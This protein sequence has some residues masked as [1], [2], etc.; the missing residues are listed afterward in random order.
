[1]PTFLNGCG[2]QQVMQ[3]TVPTPENR[4]MTWFGVDEVMIARIVAELTANGADTA[5]LYFQHQ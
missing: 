4:F 2:M 3:I 1:M 5:D